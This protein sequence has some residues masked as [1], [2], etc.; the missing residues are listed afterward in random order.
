[1]KNIGVIDI[2]V[3]IQVMKDTGV[4]LLHHYAEEHGMRLCTIVRRGIESQNW[5]DV[6]A[7]KYRRS[8]LF[9]I[10]VD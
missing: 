3:L 9:C 10:K 4:S 5:L 2:A 6:S 8:I 7:Q 1:M